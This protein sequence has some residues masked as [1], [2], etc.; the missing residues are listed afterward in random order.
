MIIFVMILDFGYTG[1]CWANALSYLGRLLGSLIYM[2]VREDNFTFYDDV[3]FF[4]CETVSNL[5]PILKLSINAML[6][7]ICPLWSFS[8]INIMAAFYGTSEIAAQS[9]L[10]SLG[11]LFM[12]IPECYNVAC[13]ILSG[14][15]I[16]EF[17]PIKA[18]KLYK[19]ALLMAFIL[20][21][22]QLLVLKFAE[23]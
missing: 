22:V 13:Q 23:S 4:S 7:T 21:V 11:F 8:I 17:L 10:R 19:A 15:A 14:N 9:A 6:M 2:K 3:R 1:L 20:T 5:G 18:L 16:G 12:L